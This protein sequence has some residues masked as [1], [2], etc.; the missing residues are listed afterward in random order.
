MSDLVKAKA[1]VRFWSDLLDSLLNDM[2]VRDRPHNLPRGKAPALK[3]LFKRTQMKSNSFPGNPSD[4][5]LAKHYDTILKAAIDEA[6]KY[7]VAKSKS[8]TTQEPYELQFRADSNGAEE[9]DFLDLNS[10]VDFKLF[11]LNQLEVAAL[12]DGSYE[13]RQSDAILKRLTFA[14]LRLGQTELANPQETLTGKREQKT[15]AAAIQIGK[16]EEVEEISDNYQKKRRA[17]KVSPI[18][19]PFHETDLR[20]DSLD[21]MMKSFLDPKQQEIRKQVRLQERV[22]ERAHE[23]ELAREQQESLFL[24]AARAFGQLRPSQTTNSGKVCKNC[25][26]ICE[27]NSRFCSNCG[28]N[29]FAT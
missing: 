18:S 20:E 28:N 8:S 3:E 11:Q 24:G 26:Q 1:K 6:A 12:N 10:T 27:P 17:E 15:S 23:R 21:S 29:N 14:M 22:Q 16:D 13:E 25:Y 7:E 4:R 2:A 19:G 9:E 5:T